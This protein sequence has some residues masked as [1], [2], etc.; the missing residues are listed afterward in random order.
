MWASPCVVLDAPVPVRV[1]LLKEEYAHYISEPE[2]LASQLEC[3]T[4]LHGKETIQ[5]W[6]ALARSREWDALVEALLLKHYDP[7]YNRST[8]K[9]Y[10]KLADAPHYT[11]PD[12]SPAAFRALA[13]IVGR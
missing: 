9:H 4:V 12:A 5:R 1:Q 7:A 2:A 10:P 13:E 8:L 3:L 6:Q 11:L